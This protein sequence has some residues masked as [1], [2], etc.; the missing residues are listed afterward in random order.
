MRPLNEWDADY[1][2]EV[3][4][5]DETG[6]LEKKA[7]IGFD[8]KKDATKA[9]IAKQVCAFANS[10][11]GFIAFGFKDKDK[12]GAGLDGG[13]SDMVGTQTIKDW[14]EG[15]IPKQHDPPIE[16]CEARF[17]HHPTIHQPDK[18]VLVIAVP[19]GERRPHRTRN[20]EIAYLRVGAHSAPMRTQTLL[21]MNSRGL[22]PKGSVVDL[23]MIPRPFIGGESPNP[24][25]PQFLLNPVVML[26]S[27][28]ICELW[29]LE[30][31][32]SLAGATF[33]CY[34]TAGMMNGITKIEGCTWEEVSINMPEDGMLFVRGKEPLFP[35]RRTPIFPK[36]R[37][38]ILTL[39]GMVQR[40]EIV[41]NLFASSALPSER[42]FRYEIS[43]GVP[44]QMDS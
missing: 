32:A 39:N 20:D 12:M 4:A 23:G 18:G 7:S 35:R 1:L 24:N 10:G 44:L 34:K 22:V 16:G 25:Q 33:G 41:A 31:Q 26:D 38:A 2:D 36:N 30:L 14:V 21:D 9:E 11:E 13:V 15:V 5:S 3:A 19:L 17:L 29:A 8:P 42:R 27:G 37:G 28:P 6:N 40:F 43:N